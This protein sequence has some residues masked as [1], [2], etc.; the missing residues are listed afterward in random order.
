MCP[1]LTQD[2]P[3]ENVVR[4][5]KNLTS[6]LPLLKNYGFYECNGHRFHNKLEALLYATQTGH[7]VH[8][9]FCEDIFSK[10]NWTVEPTRSMEQLYAERA[11]QIRNRYDYVVLH[12]SGGRDS[13]NIM[14]TFI[15]NNLTIDEVFIRGTYSHIPTAVKTP[16][17]FN[18]YAECFRAALPL[19]KL[20]KEKYYPHM[21][22]TMV[23]ITDRLIRIA[24][25]RNWIECNNGGI[26]LSEM[27]CPDYDIFNPAWAKMAESGKKICHLVGIDKPRLHLRDGRFYFAFLDYAV[28]QFGAGRMSDIDLPVYTELFYWSPDSAMMLVKQAHLV[29]QFIKLKGIA[30]TLDKW[31]Y[32]SNDCTATAISKD[33]SFTSEIGSVIY[34]RTLFPMLWDAPKPLNYMKT[35]CTSNLWQDPNA[36]WFINW[37]NGADYALSKIDSKYKDHQYNGELK[38]IGFPSRFYDLGT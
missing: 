11:Q 12:F 16:T 33:R 28:V 24:K 19:S 22:I 37:K 15:K 32:D 8:W 21:E 23:D 31:Q 36:D 6:T 27:F 4:Y 17:E 7:P 38:P 3:K 20:I 14:E 10:I 29:K 34:N 5:S 18:Y 9:N 13:L 25:D 1:V 35:E 26:S 30:N 2:T